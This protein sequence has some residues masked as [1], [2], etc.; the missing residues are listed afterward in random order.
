MIYMSENLLLNKSKEFAVHI[1]K[2]CDDL[3]NCV[4]IREQLIRCGTSIGANLHEAQYAQGKADF[5][6]KIKIALKEC[7][8]TEYW[9]ELLYKSQK[10]SISNYDELSAEAG[11]IRR[12]LI[13]SCVTIEENLKNKK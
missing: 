11:V 12:M 6:S 5:F 7:H 8:E 1:I 4:A 10:I 13:K 9:L 2:F 3:R